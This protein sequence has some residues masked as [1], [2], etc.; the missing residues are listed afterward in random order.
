MDI[1]IKTTL[2]FI[3]AMSLIFD[4]L[5][6]MI[7]LEVMNGSNVEEFFL[8]WTVFLFTASF[9][10]AFIMDLKLLN[11]PAVLGF[12]ALS[13]GCI[14]DIYMLAISSENIISELIVKSNFSTLHL[15]TADAV[16]DA[17]V[18]L[19]MI[20]FSLTMFIMTHS[21]ASNM[22]GEDNH[23]NREGADCG[24]GRV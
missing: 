3:L 2:R 14:V 12:G 21:A 10:A 8:A 5:S 20:T 13:I 1:S 4:S 18:E 9:L 22:L 6:D 19:M 11:I 24:C 16:S 17:K 15:N 23:H 7:H